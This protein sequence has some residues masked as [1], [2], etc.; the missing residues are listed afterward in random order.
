MTCHFKKAEL[1]FYNLSQLTLTIFI[2]LFFSSCTS[3]PNCPGK[4]Y[5]AFIRPI[6]LIGKSHGQLN[7]NL[8]SELKRIVTNSD[9]GLDSE[10]LIGLCERAEVFAK[11]TGVDLLAAEIDLIL[12]QLP[13]LSKEVS[14]F[15]HCHCDTTSDKQLCLKMN[16]DL[17]IAERTR[18]KN[19]LI[20]TAN[21]AIFE[22]YE[23]RVTREVGDPNSIN[24]MITI[25]QMEELIEQGKYLSAMDLRSSY[26]KE[27]I[28][29]D[30][31]IESGKNCG[32]PAGEP[33]QHLPFYGQ[34]RRLGIEITD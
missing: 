16:K 34:L 7:L 20:E 15:C 3:N 11:E 8:R 31:I 10:Q 19:K 13:T 24:L 30:Q 22:A 33:I 5:R 17:E 12:S 28:S 18:A 1:N 21:I 6:A 29:Y 25:K 9:E 23:H 4:S 27:A 2:V 32:C 14:A 26:Y